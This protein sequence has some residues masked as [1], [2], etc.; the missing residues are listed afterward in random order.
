MNKSIVFIHGAWLNSRSWENVIPFFET[1]GYKCSAPEWPYRDPNKTAA[2]L[3]ENTPPELAQIGLKEITDHYESLIREFPEQPILIGHSFGGLVVQQLL[4]RGFGS[5]GIGFDSAAPEGVLALDWTV[6]KVN[7]PVLFKW[8]G[9]EQVQHMSFP[10]FQYAFT[11]TFPLEEQQRCYDRY[12]VPET[13]RI[14][15]QAAFAQLDP[16]HAIRVNFNNNERAPLL[17]TAGELDHLV[18]AHVSKANYEHY[19]NSSARTDF[20]E[21]G[22]R[23]H[24]ITAGPGWEEVV[25]FAADWLEQL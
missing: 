21:F 19:K 10:E 5:A 4:D 20:K 23:A 18:P 22:G 3:R 14:F 1:R 7:A 9:W 15:F 2:E 13:G 17:L 6:L 8:M 12:L 11:N 25:G 24:L 16:H